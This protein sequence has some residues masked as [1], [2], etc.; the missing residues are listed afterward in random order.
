MRSQLLLSKHGSS[1]GS[2]VWRAARGVRAPHAVA[3]RRNPQVT[4]GSAPGPL[5][6]HS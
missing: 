3:R 6:P 1:Q 5:T 2:P 4:T